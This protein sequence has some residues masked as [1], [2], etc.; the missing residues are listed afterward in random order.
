[1]APAESAGTKIDVELRFVAEK[2]EDMAK[3]IL[4][5]APTSFFND[6]GGHIRILEE[7]RELER[8]GH[9]VII[10][11]YYL[12]NDV[13]G[14]HIERTPPLP[15][16]ADYEVGSSRHKIAFDLFL[17]WKTVQVALRERPDVVHGHMHEGALIGWVISRLLRVPLIFDYQGSLTAEMTDHGFLRPG[18]FRF[19]MVRRLERFI[20][21]RAGA[22]LT[23]SKQA[24]TLLESEFN[25]PADRIVP[26]PDCVDIVAFDRG[27]FSAAQLA[28][29]KEGFGIPADRPVVVYLGLLTDYQGIP[30]LLQ[31]AAHLKNAAHD[32]H[33]LIMGFPNIDRYT[34]MAQQLNVADRVTFTG[35]IPFEHAPFFLSLGDIAITTKMSATEGSGKMLNYMA[36]AL[37]TVAYETPV[38]RDYLGEAG[39]FVPVGDVVGLAVAIQKLADNPERRSTLGAALR[40]RA[41]DNFTWAVASDIVEAQYDRLIGRSK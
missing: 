25:L 40:Q 15:Y 41:A 38:H 28:V 16:R 1:M 32:V 29:Q 3:K 9:L 33:F 13:D 37:P 19:R 20:N 7:A 23:S 17:L 24:Q 35:K 31:A 12:G 6:Y 26:L 8:R 14:L 10:V 36:L 34:A 18:G 5:I 11:T 4:M 27:K 30:H 22:I 39:V 21:G 2:A